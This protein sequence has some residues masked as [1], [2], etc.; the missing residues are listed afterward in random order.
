MCNIK[1]ICMVIPFYYKWNNYAH[2]KSIYE[3]LQIQGYLV[4]I[5]TKK[6]IE[7]I[8]F[9]KYDIAMLHGSGAILTND[10]YQQ[11]DIPILSFGHSDPNLFNEIHFNQGNI[12]FTNDLKLSRILKEKPVYY[13]PTACDMRYHVNL[14]LNKTTDI[15]TYGK[16][17]HPFVTNRN[18]IV[19]KLRRKGFKIRCFGREW[20]KHEDTHGFIEGEELSKEICQARIVLDLSNADTAWSHRI[21]EVSARGTTCLTYDRED[22]REMFMP[23]KEI[24]TYKTIEDMMSTLDYYLN[25]EEELVLIGK[26]AQERC[27]KD[28]DISVRIQE[29]LKILKEIGL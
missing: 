16:G 27:Y 22:T 8:D 26:N 9:T 11:C 29:L 14:N 17:S 25:A 28:H 23:Y 12:Y 3:Y 18:K 20:D 13:F 19:N 2:I 4:D 15:L 7:D 5:F 21:F 1:K 6:E 24:L 10:I